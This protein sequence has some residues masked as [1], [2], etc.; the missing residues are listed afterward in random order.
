M[1]P[2]QMLLAADF[3]A[4][5]HGDFG[6]LVSWAAPFMLTA[7]QKP[8]GC[9]WTLEVH[10]E[11]GKQG[12]GKL[13]AKHCPRQWAVGL[14]L[15]AE[16]A[17]SAS[18]ACAHCEEVSSGWMPAVQR[19]QCVSLQCRGAERL[20][21]PLQQ[22]G[23]HPVHVCAVSQSGVG[24]MGR[25]SVSAVSEG[26]SVCWRRVWG[27]L[28]TVQ[29]RGDAVPAIAVCWGCAVHR[30][31]QGP[32][33]GICAAEWA[34]SLCPSN[35]GMGSAPLPV[36]ATGGWQCPACSAGGMMLGAPAS[37]QCWMGGGFVSRSARLA[38]LLCWQ[39]REGSPALSLPWQCP[40]P[41]Q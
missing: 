27:C 29:Q 18:A 4:P 3:R 12:T 15:G 5:N 14:W 33:C 17:G 36:R 40:V 30:E 24:G 16:V 21:L 23:G 6:V 7:Q 39:C 8:C 32:L 28:V 11:S 35:T 2:G 26:N 22:W 38:V 34:V 13:V 37:L 31:A 25:N 10:S 1:G 41:L 19:V 9:A 20:P